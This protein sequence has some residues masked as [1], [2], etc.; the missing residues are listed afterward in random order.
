MSRPTVDQASK[1]NFVVNIQDSEFGKLV[2]WW[3]ERD[4]SWG[5]VLG[6]FCGKFWY[7]RDFVAANKKQTIIK[8]CTGLWVE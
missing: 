5:K 7:L 4:K 3:H 6:Q 1:Q 2:V 8:L